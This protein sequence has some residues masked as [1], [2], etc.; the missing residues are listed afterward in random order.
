MS[1]QQITELRLN[2]SRSLS[3]TLADRLNWSWTLFLVAVLAQ[4]RAELELD[5]QDMES[6]KNAASLARARILER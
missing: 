2:Y 4:T 3:R 6:L 1:N 5:D